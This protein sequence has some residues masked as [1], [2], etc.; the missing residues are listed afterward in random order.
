MTKIAIVEDHHLVRH[1]FVETLKKFKDIH[2]VFDTDDGNSLFEYLIKYTIDLLILDLQM[3]KISGLD[4]CKYIKI[5]YPDIKILI[6]TQLV[7]EL[8][9]LNLIKAGANGY[10]SKLINS[11]EI[12]IAIRTIMNN[13]Y[14]FDY[15]TKNI[16]PELMEYKTIDKLNL[17]NKYELTER[18]IQII[19]LSSQKKDN[20]FI[21]QNLNIS[22]RTVETHKR[23]IIN[24]TNQKNFSDVLMFSLKNQI[25]KIEEL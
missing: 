5:N 14:Y 16:L 19:R 4:I 21:A 22:I 15:S 2:V 25:I 1:G 20:T 9:V 7:D 24:K 13:K 6:L 10:S 11:S 12:E 3:N 17:F 8:T 23:R 18:E